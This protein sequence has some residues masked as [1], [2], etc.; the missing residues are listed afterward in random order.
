MVTTVV[1]VRIRRVQ[2]PDASLYFR[3]T[4][5][6]SVNATSWIPL[7]CMIGR[8]RSWVV[9][10]VRLTAPKYECHRMVGRGIS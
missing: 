5:A 8:A 6:V 3:G 7:V 2:G 1:V 10:Y 4:V 9:G